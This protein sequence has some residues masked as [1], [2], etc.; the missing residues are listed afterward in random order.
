MEKKKFKNNA[1][2]LKKIIPKKPF[3]QKSRLFELSLKTFE[4][5]LPDWNKI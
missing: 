4:N 1:T 2:K 3:W 5:K